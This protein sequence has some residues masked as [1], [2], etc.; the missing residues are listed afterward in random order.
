[1]AADGPQI[2]KDYDVDVARRAVHIARWE[3]M[4]PFVA[5]SRVGIQGSMPG[6]SQ[7]TNVY[8]STTL[9]AAELM[10]QFLAGQ[11]MNPTQRWMEYAPEDINAQDDDEAKEWCEE[12][13]DRSLKRLAES[14]F[15]GE[16]TE[17]LTDYVGFGTGLLIGEE[18]PQPINETLRGFRGFNFTAVKTGRFVIREGNDGLVD[19]FAR[20]HQMTMQNIKDRWGATGNYPESIRAAIAS[21]KQEASFK[22]IHSVYPRPKAEQHGGGA[23]GAPW[24]SVWTA[25]DAKHVIQESGYRQFCGAIPRYH[26]T[27]GDDYG[28]GRGD[29]AF[30]DTWTLNSAKKMGL[31]D[32]ALKIKPPILHRSDAVMSGLRLIPGGANSINTHGRAIADAIAPWQTGSNPEVSHINEEELRKSIRTIFFV[33]QILQLLEVNKSEMTAFEFAKKINLLFQILGP[34]YSRFVVELLHRVVDNVFELQY[35]AGDFSPPP[36]SLQRGSGGIRLRFDNPIARAQRAGDAEGLAFVLSDL[37]PLAQQYPDMFDWL[38]RDKAVPAIF[39]LRGIPAHWTN[40][41]AQVAQ[42]RQARDKQ[43]AQDLQIQRAKDMAEAAGK[44]APL[45]KVLQD[46]GGVATGAPGA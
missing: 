46:S 14:M 12:S 41:P 44:A 32:W 30:P 17:V 31:E 24:A 26:R 40:T 16:S 7:L 36:A 33:E 38:D 19:R 42:I 20:E 11:V 23:A 45:A 4:A 13:R 22:I 34:V 5:P 15:Y 1:M 29:I 2:I 25:Y 28:R 27:P 9:L 35:R 21:N 18:K 6:M 39:A 10:A 8:D 43:N 37:G 3:R